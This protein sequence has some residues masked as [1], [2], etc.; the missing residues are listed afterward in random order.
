VPQS[1]E[2]TAPGGSDTET[3]SF[4][5]GTYRMEVTAEEM[6][7]A[8]VSSAWAN[9]VA[10]VWT[11]T[12]DDGQL[13]SSDVNGITG[14]AQEDPPH[15]YCFSGNRIY[16]YFNPPCDDTEWWSAK[17]AFEDG[18]LS[19]TDFRPGPESDVEPGGLAALWTTN[20]WERTS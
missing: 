14:N 1:S 12:F 4:P 3:T 6:I 19:F 5:E 11:W 20:P 9:D 10:G 17:W 16:V 8:G 2:A 18:A 7:D 13:L 15:A